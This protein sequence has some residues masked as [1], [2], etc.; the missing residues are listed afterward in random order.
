MPRPG[1]RYVDLEIDTS[2]NSRHLKFLRDE[3]LHSHI[4]EI[5]LSGSSS[6]MTCFEHSH[7]QF[8]VESRV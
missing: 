6:L 4:D 1:R 5:T 2:C 8:A 3:L 7:G